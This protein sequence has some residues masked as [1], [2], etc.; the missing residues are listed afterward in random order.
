MAKQ[1]K[2][3]SPSKTAR[4]VARTGSPAKTRGSKSRGPKT[5]TAKSSAQ[6]PTRVLGVTV[7]KTVTNALDGLVNS[8]RGRE[9]LA[10]ALV[11]A[12]SAAAAAL[13]KSPDS[14][15]VAKAREAVSEAGEQVT[16]AT[17]DLSAAAAG[18]L[19]EVVTEAARSFLPASVTRATKRKR[20][21]E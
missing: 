12:A 10:S 16:S 5:K 15:Q 4:R 11:A 20:G 21:G 17:K 7:P 18:A 14:P 2:T 8:P 19:A 9:I 6:R 1:P 3:R 13:V